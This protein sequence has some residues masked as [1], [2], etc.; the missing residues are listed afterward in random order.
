MYYLPSNE[1]NGLVRSVSKHLHEVSRIGQR[2]F[3]IVSRVPSS[4]HTRGILRRNFAH[5]LI[6]PRA[7]V[8]RDNDP[9]VPVRAQCAR[10][11]TTAI[12]LFE[13]TP[14]APLVRTRTRPRFWSRR[15]LKL[16]RFDTRQDAATFLLR[17]KKLARG[18]GKVERI[19]TSR[20]TRRDE[21]C[22]VNV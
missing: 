4:T 10:H 11:V 2:L 6:D 22:G 20:E 13:R 19:R 12:F 21:D 1:Y 8:A 5:G 18:K 17:S 7:Q 15:P 16:A 3:A 14:P 9:F